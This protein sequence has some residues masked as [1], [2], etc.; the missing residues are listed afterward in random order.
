[1]ATLLVTFV[2]SR[3]VP[4]V[5]GDVIPE[6]PWCDANGATFEQPIRIA[7]DGEALAIDLISV[8]PV[9][10]P[11]PIPQIPTLFNK[12]GRD[13]ISARS[14]SLISTLPIPVPEPGRICEAIAAQ[15][16]ALHRTELLED[17]INMALDRGM[18]DAM[19]AD[20]LLDVQ[21]ALQDQI[22]TLPTPI[23]D[24]ADLCS[25]LPVPIP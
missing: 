24:P 18:I 14:A 7:L 15:N 21:G 2:I 16:R 10:I 17:K 12:I 5:Y 9:P 1:M 4:V 25:T 22:M 19:T 20:L 8:L 11:K 6:D 13:V 3:P 23:P